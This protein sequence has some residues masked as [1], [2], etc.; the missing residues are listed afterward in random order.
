MASKI[1]DKRDD[2]DVDIANFPFVDRDIPRD[3][4][5]GVYISQPIR[6]ARASNHVVE[7]IYRIEYQI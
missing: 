1:Y 7:M 3:P 2:F 4:S 5:N 6:F